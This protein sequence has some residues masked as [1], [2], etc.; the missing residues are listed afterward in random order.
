MN[1]K[2]LLTQLLSRNLYQK[3]SL[4]IMKLTGFL[5]FAF[6]MQVSAKSVSQTITISKKNVPLTTVF[7][8]FQ[9]QTGYSFLY[10]LELVDKVG[11]INVELKNESLERAL[12]KCLANTSLSFGIVE[13]TV[14][15]K[16]KENQSPLTE[17]E[18]L[19]KAIDIRGVV[20]DDH[21]NPMEGVSVLV[22]DS[23]KGTSTDKSGQ[24]ILNDLQEN[25]ILVFSMVGY[26]S[27]FISVKNKTIMNV[28]LKLNVTQQDEIVINTGYQSFAKERASGSYS[29]VSAKDMDG[30]LQTNI[31]D[32]LEGMAAGVTSYKGKLQIRGTSTINGN[33]N[34]LVVV[35][36]VPYEGS[37]EAINPY[38]VANITILKDATAAS[39]YGARSAN[40]VIVI[41]TNKGKAGP[42]QIRL[43]SSL[44]FTPLPD[45]DYQNKMS[46]R[47]LVGFQSEMFNYQSGDYNTLDPRRS[48]NDVYRLLYERK[49]GNIT[50]AELQTR[51]D[52]YRN[53]DR[54]DQT[55]D[56]LLR[57]ESLVQ[58][59]NIQFSGGSEKYQFNLSANY[60][61]NN[62]Y[63]RNQSSNRIGYNLRNN[64]NLTKW[65]NADI[66]LLGSNTKQDFDNGFSGF[67]NLNSGKASYYMLRNTDGTPAQWYNSKSQFEID[68]LNSLGLEDET[69]K[70]LNEISQQHNLTTSKYNNLN[71]GANVK[72]IPGMSLDVRFQ[73][74]RTETYAKQLYSK[75]AVSV[76]SQINDAT[77]F[78]ADSTKINYIPVGGQINETRGDL[79]SYTLRG[80][81]NYTNSFNGKHDVRFIAGGERR[82]IASSSTGVYKY[83]YDDYSL[84]YKPVDELLLSQYIYNTQA[85]FN[86]FSLSKA[87]SGFRYVENRYVS[88]FGNGS[89]TYNNRLTAT[90]SIRMDQSNLFGTDPKYQYKPLWSA[91]LLYSLLENKYS[92]LN[93][94]A[95]RATYGI[96]GNVAKNSG[97]F[98][99]VS[100]SYYTNYYT[101]DFQSE[102]SSPPNSG[103]RW[104]KTKVTNL[105]IDFKMFNNRFSGSIDLYN[106]N[107]TD[108]LGDLT[109]DPT[110]G[111]S[112]I[113]VNY[114]SMYNRGIDLS[115]NYDNI[116]TNHF[117]WST[118]LN[119]NYNK[120]ELTRLENSSNTVVSYIYSAQNRVGK[121]MG[122]IY[123]IHY[124]GLDDQG[125]PTAFTK[126]KSIVKSSQK[127]DVN[128]LVYNGTS[129]PPYSASLLNTIRYKDFDL[130]FMFIYYGGN[131]MRDVRSVYL[132]RYPELNYNTNLDKNVLNYWKKPGDELNPDV[133]P[134]YLNGASSSITDLWNAA[135]SGVEKGDFIKLRDMTLGYNLSGKFMKTDAIKGLRLSLQMQNLF[136]WAANKQHLD[137]EVWS[138]TSL[139]PSRGT[140][141]PSTYTIGL[142]VNF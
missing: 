36:G 95:V 88:F 35:D 57:K 133:S 74:E 119:F 62:P 81:L 92:W 137:P 103:L 45:R 41:T 10:N 78:E 105:G 87:E 28:T 85:L 111:W 80:Q 66:T 117:K 40:G 108:L 19:P 140:R 67:S 142:S 5:L 116:I 47:E 126:D 55:V 115:L 25:D 134:A 58:Q 89:Y 43:N 120:N 113:L 15:I 7:K 98:L 97:P 122:A 90:G 14:V 16:P 48:L 127:L 31:L 38:E 91:G 3:K 11:K 106:K 9:K 53:Q 50:E 64:F 49:Q 132:S 39:I 65:L 112:S 29:V 101:N 77:V 96:N 52:V 18:E 131:V 104:E 37:L 83:G 17:N 130:F 129:V 118:T 72:L 23:K 8:E 46:S 63:E 21:G 33:S 70:P 94:I 51:L 121:P 26:T 124:A 4:R 56:E 12:N 100:D 32:R 44:K 128:D 109:S 22:K 1:L 30:K 79:N 20:K 2:L 125:M 107:T 84:N 110:L 27:Q 59:H 6:F 73:T 71:I 136:Y 135:S 69:Y 82:Q 60:L 138:G 34:P 93:R 42:L 102:I 68:R 123:S 13:N 24:F 99:I 141:I 75:D 114:G 54:Y 76:K 86:Q 61:Q 139:S